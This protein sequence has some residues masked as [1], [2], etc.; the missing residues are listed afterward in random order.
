[1]GGGS[2][3]RGIDSLIEQNTKINV[4][5]AEEPE[6]AVIKGCGELISDPNKMKLLKKYLGG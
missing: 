4:E 5:V 3:L 2:K 6:L 1:V